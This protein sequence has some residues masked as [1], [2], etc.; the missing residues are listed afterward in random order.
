MKKL[1][2][3]FALIGIFNILAQASNPPATYNV[4]IGWDDANCSCND[5]TTM[6]VKVDIYTYPG[7]VF[8][9]TSDW[10]QA[11]SSPHTI[12]DSG[13]INTDCS[14]N[15]YKVIAYVK[16]IDN[17]GICCEGEGSELCSGEDL[18]VGFPFASSITL[19]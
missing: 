18:Y 10:E 16:Y 12:Y 3:L 14:G 19:Y 1:I 5:P 11:S 17:S 8:V 13:N 4:T 6:Y 9:C 2:F 7:D 15:C